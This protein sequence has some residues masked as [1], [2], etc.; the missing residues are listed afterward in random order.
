M[1]A[2]SADK[3]KVNGP[4]ADGSYAITFE[5]GEYEQEKVAE[6]L[7]LPTQTAL[8]VKVDIYGTK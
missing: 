6:I 8:H 1:I 7:K 2:F 4:R 5:T 3:V